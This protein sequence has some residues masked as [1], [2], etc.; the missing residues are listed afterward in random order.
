MNRGS[1]LLF[2]FAQ[3]DIT[4]EG[5]VTTIGFG[6]ADETSRGVLGGLCAQVS[7]WQ[8]GEE[9]C[10]LAAIDHIGFSLSHAGELRDRIGGALGVGREKVMLCFSHTHAGPNDSAEPD[11]FRMVC[12]RATRAAQ[13]AAGDMR[14]VDAAWGNAEADI[15]VN[16]RPGNGALDRRIGILKVRDRESGAPRLLLL[17]LT[18]H[19]NALKADN[20][21]VSPDYFG[22]VR[23]ALS[24][25]Y[26]CPV[27]ATQG[28]SGN[29]SPKYFQSC[30]TPP[31]AGDERYVRSE[32]ALSDLAEIVLR[33][34]SPVID[35]LAPKPATRLAMC[36]RRIALVADVPSEARAAEIA[37]EALTLCGIDGAGWLG[38]VRRLNAAGI[39]V[40]EEAV[41]AQYFRLGEGCLCGVPNEIMCEFALG[42]SAL[43][44]D[45]RFYFGGYTNGCTGYFPTE[46][47]FDKG[48]YEVYWSMLTY[49]PYFGR[50]FP[51]RRDAASELVAF[52][53]KNAPR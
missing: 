18:A 43:L 30:L 16:R 29:V 42:A 8:L 1:E 17:R 36:A 41:E 3:A 45:D 21:L 19:A 4:P 47:E 20:Y 24:E 35:A 5:P 34:A 33:D 38:E 27:M 9:R 31:D 25:K 52:A 39:R 22:A 12:R 40:Q 28:A 26:G 48:G 32:T 2:G 51:L 15:G 44:S 49:Y 6:R 50:V 53:A 10:C 14:P 46:E 11:W 13:A 7:V 23:D 37:R